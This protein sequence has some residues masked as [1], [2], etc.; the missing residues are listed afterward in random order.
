MT[1]VKILTSYFLTSNIQKHLI[2]I[3][4]YCI[5]NKKGSVYMPKIKHINADILSD[6]EMTK[7]S[8]MFENAEKKMDEKIY[9]EIEQRKSGTYKNENGIWISK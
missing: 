8:E 1:D 3:K 4:K 6:E 2:F 5:I 7:F 9:K